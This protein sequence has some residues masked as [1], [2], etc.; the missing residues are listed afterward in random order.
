AVGKK[1]ERLALNLSA[2]N[3]SYPMLLVFRFTHAQDHVEQHASL[4]RLRSPDHWENGKAGV[5]VLFLS[6]EDLAQVDHGYVVQLI[7]WVYDDGYLLSWTGLAL[8]RK[9]SAGQKQK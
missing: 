6:G 3:L 8:L 5:P 2:V 4:V 1:R 9:Q 7:R